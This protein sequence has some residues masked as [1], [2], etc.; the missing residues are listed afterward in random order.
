MLSFFRS[1]F[2]GLD[3]AERDDVVRVLDFVIRNHRTRPS[4]DLLGAYRP[5]KPDLVNGLACYSANLVLIRIL[6]AGGPVPV[7]E[8]VRDDDEWASALAL[9]KAG[10]RADGWHAMLTWIE[11]AGD[12]LGTG[13]VAVSP[14]TADYRHA[15]LLNDAAAQARSAFGLA[16]HDGIAVDIGRSGVSLLA[17]LIADLTGRTPPVDMSTDPPGTTET[18][19][20]TARLI[21][22]VLERLLLSW[23][24]DSDFLHGYLSVLLGLDQ[25]KE[26]DATALLLNICRR[27]QVIGNLPALRDPDLYREAADLAILLAHC[28]LP[29]GETQ[30]ED[31]WPVIAVLAEQRPET[32]TVV[33]AMSE[34]AKALV[35]HLV[36]SMREDP[37]SDETRPS[38]LRDRSYELW[39]KLGNRDQ[40]R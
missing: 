18:D 26:I 17:T 30:A 32:E 15:A 21:A 28:L 13:Q 4:L 27:P 19:P 22:S 7:G 33:K 25:L 36:A 1:L 23:Q 9:W 11:R 38:N 40:K 34:E 24:P 12:H 2:T 5:T 14:E 8:I 3:R 10:L 29:A 31:W 20:T 39:D 6:I 16:L 37:N 35:R